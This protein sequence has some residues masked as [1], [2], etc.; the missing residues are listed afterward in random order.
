[1]RI[2]LA[3]SVTILFSLLILLAV[4]YKTMMIIIVIIIGMFMSIGVPYEALI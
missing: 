4:S 2:V 3:L 1:M